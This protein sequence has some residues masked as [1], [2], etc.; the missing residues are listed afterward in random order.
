MPLRQHHSPT[1][2]SQRVTRKGVPEL[3]QARLCAQLGWDVALPSRTYASRRQLESFCLSWSA[4]EGVKGEVCSI[5]PMSV[6]LKARKLQVTWKKATS[7][8][9]VVPVDDLQS[10]NHYIL[11]KRDGYDAQG[12]KCSAAQCAQLLLDY[13]RWPL[14]EKTRNRKKIAVGDRIAV[15]LAGCSEVVAVAVVSGIEQWKNVH[16]RKYPLELDG[17]PQAQLLLSDVRP[18]APS[19]AVRDR[20]HRLSFIT[21]G[22]PKWGV[23]F[24]GGTRGVSTADFAVL[25][26]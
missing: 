23:A 25:T 8:W 9:D 26:A 5:F 6:C 12:H 13:G 19:I 2:D 10:V 11:I 7:W 3:L 4:R 24:M 17:V 15:Y 21:Q 18:L 22:S 1:V 16:A 14:W 20:L